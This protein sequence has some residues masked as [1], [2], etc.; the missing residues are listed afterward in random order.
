MTATDPEGDAMRDWDTDK[1]LCE[2]ATEGPWYMDGPYWWSQTRCGSVVT[3]AGRRPV[4][5]IEGRS[6]RDLE[7]A[8]FIAAAR[9]ALPYWLDRCAELEAENERLR[10]G[11][12][13]LLE[14][15]EDMRGYVS[16]YFAEK[17]DHDGELARARAVLEQGDKK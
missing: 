16:D 11:F 9:T 7:D 12:A 2:A 17:W 13:A 6:E 8:H 5:V 15:A 4:A 14:A 1:A 3:E 10:G